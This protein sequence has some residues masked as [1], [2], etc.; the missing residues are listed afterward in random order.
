M[1]HVLVEAFPSAGLDR[2]RLAVLTEKEN[3]AP[4]SEEY[5]RWTAAG[6]CS[7]VRRRSPARFDSLYL[8]VQ[9]QPMTPL[10]GLQ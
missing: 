6:T 5:S 1:R 7:Q 3:H 2:G 10:P 8:E 4:L 9:R